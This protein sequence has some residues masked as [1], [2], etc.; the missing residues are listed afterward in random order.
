MRNLTPKEM[1]QEMLE[2]YR[3]VRRSIRL[4]E[5]EEDKRKNHEFKLQKEKE[6]E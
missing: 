4:K 3:E 2:A 1:E 6:N 5:I